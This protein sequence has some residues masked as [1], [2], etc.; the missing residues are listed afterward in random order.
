LRLDRGGRDVALVRDSA[1]QL[2]G[3]AEA[4]ERR[5]DSDLLVQPVRRLAAFGSGSGGKYLLKS[6]GP[7][8]P[9]RSGSGCKPG[10]APDP[11]G[12]IYRIQC[13]GAALRA[14]SVRA[15]CRHR[16]LQR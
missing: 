9:S 3:K 2:G 4:F 11:R 12:P 14:Y 13:S 5:T 1:A 7:R 6:S 16:I 10:E 15:F 8:G